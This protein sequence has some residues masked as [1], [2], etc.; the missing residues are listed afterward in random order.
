MCVVVREEKMNNFLTI[1]EIN[2]RFRSEWVLL[3]NPKTNRKL[4]VLGGR[5]RLHDKDK[6]RLYKE[7]AK[8]RL[9]HIAVLYTGQIPKGTVF[10]L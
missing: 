4:E 9:K 5:V 1:D 2:E 10:W 6:E 8:L 3:E 7:A